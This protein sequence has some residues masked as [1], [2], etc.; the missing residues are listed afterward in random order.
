[1]SAPEQPA[2]NTA[3][4]LVTLQEPDHG[5]SHGLADVHVGLGVAAI[6]GAGA[7]W[8]VHEWVSVHRGDISLERW[9]LSTVRNVEH[10]VQ[11]ESIAAHRAL[12]RLTEGRG[13][14]LGVGRA[15]LHPELFDEGDEVGLVVRGEAHVAGIAVALPPEEA[16]NLV[17]L[18]A[19]E[20]RGEVAQ[21]L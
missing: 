21:N 6:V 19:W 11:D 18:G 17:T 15:V 3:S 20:K 8:G 14:K 4:P 12:D 5:L 13:D 10:G 2:A 16:R 7:A 9:V 1:M